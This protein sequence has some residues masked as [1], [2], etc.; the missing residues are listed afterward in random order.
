VTASLDGPCALGVGV[1]LACTVGLFAVGTWPAY[2]LSTLRLPENARF[3]VRRMVTRLSIGLLVAATG[4]V[5][6]LL[7]FRP[8]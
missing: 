4:G 1:L 7:A 2:F 3:R 8:C 6:A 5:L